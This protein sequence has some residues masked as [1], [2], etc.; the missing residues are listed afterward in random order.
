MH[1]ETQATAPSLTGA[2]QV[3]WNLSD[4]YPTI[5]SGEFLADFQRIAADAATFSQS[6]RGGLAALSDDQFL[7]MLQ[8]LEHIYNTAGRLS[9]RVYLEWTTRSDDEQ[10]IAWLQRV[11]E[12]LV[13]VRQQLVFV[14]IEIRTMPD[15]AF[16]RLLASPL[17]ERYRH[18]LEFNRSFA[19]HT[20]SEAEERLEAELD[21]VGINAWV[22]LFDQIHARQR[23]D[24]GGE[25]LSLQQLMRWLQD[26]DRNRRR[27]AAFALSA[28]LKDQA[29]LL[30]YIV[31]MVLTDAMMSDRR[32]HYATWLSHRNKANKISDQA[33]ES[34]VTAVTEAYPLAARYYALKRRILGLDEFYEW[35]RNAPVA[36]DRET[37]PWETARSIVL[38][39]F[40][41]FDGRMSSVASL[42]FERRW[43]DAPVRPGKQSGA[44]SS[45]T[46]PDVHPYIMLNYTG[47][48]RDVATLAHELGHGVHQYLARTQ[49]YFNAGTPLTIAETASVFGEMLVFDAMME[50]AADDR[51]RLSLLMD[52]LGDIVNTVFRQIALNRFEDAIHT[53][54]RTEGMLTTDT[55]NE[56][57]MA[58]QRPMYGD[59]VTLT[60]NYRWWWAYISHFV[61]TPGYVYAYAFGELLV[62]ALYQMYKSNEVERFSD[63]YIALLEA[64]G[65]D[66]P[67]NLVG[68]HFGLD[69]GAQQ[70]W[71]R[72][73]TFIASLLDRAESLADALAV[74]N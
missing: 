45:P 2:E 47:T 24:V 12:R 49:G 51:L 11:E 54:R 74:K 43:I 26:T 35:D 17:L 27:S 58:T 7:S 30:G 9:S 20:L 33:V 60:D 21:V 62:L 6:W 3:E 68:K 42:F 46:V 31:N 48:L 34:L 8:Q 41:A 18:W 23:Y 52:K 4:L 40:D 57:W 5:G 39:A 10:L 67:E 72:G 53:Y 70:F 65:S 28:G 44:Y 61:H 15:D 1:A 63:R 64:G 29:P 38:D 59:A 22:K 37:I 32:R 50:Q 71:Q 13:E 73:L 36:T 69:I 19:P 55:F 25:R 56:L 14:P 66:T 16:Q